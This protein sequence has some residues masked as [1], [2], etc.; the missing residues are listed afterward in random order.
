MDSGQPALIIRGQLGGDPRQGIR[1]EHL[2]PLIVAG[3]IVPG[4]QPLMDHPA[5]S[6]TDQP[7]ARIRSPARTVIDSG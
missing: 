3:E 1:K 4:D 2:D 5:L 7:A 6:T